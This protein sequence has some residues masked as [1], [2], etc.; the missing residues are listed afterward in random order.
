MIAD[1]LR[2]RQVQRDLRFTRTLE[3]LTPF[4]IDLIRTNRHRDRLGW[5]GPG[6]PGS[7]AMCLPTL[8]EKRVLRLELDGHN[9]IPAIYTWTAFGRAIADALTSPPKA[10]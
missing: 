6:L 1:R 9:T 8:L 7:V 4:E 3:S 2:E 10:S 5:N